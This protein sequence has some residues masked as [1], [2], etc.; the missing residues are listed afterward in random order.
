M[1]V[2]KHGRKQRAPHFFGKGDVASSCGAGVTANPKGRK[3][4]WWWR[5]GGDWDVS[6]S[7]APSGSGAG[8]E[9]EK[10]RRV[11]ARQYTRRLQRSGE[12]DAGGE[13]SEAC[14]PSNGRSWHAATSLAHRDKNCK[15]SPFIVW[16]VTVGRSALQALGS[17]INGLSCVCVEEH[18]P[19][20]I[21]P[22][23]QLAFLNKKKARTM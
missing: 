15:I 2:A 5:A 17:R 1:S 10:G 13:W 6:G 4:T 9:E 11:S 19:T 21:G 8:E 18:V 7:G 12:E 16:H 3:G 20:C 14:L 23:A 22:K